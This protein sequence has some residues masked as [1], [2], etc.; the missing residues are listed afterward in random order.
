M[1][2]ERGELMQL[3]Q[4]GSR[5]RLSVV[6]REKVGEYFD[7]LD[8]A[9]RGDKKALA[10]HAFELSGGEVDRGAIAKRVFGSV[11]SSSKGSSE[12]LRPI[13]ERMLQVM[14]TEKTSEV[15]D[16]I[17]KIKRKGNTTTYYR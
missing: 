3:G 7:L 12:N 16:P 14:T 2:G 15:F 6:R 5:K 17:N 10:R 4:D 13:L 11:P 1:E 8:A 9:N